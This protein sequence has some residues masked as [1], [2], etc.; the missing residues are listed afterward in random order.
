[1]F[2][3]LG[4]QQSIFVVELLNMDNM[5]FKDNYYTFFNTKLICNYS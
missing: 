5:I 2:Q 1:M 4:I 3:R